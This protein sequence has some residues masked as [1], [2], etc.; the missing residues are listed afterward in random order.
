MG[1]DAKFD[2]WSAGQSYE[3]YMGRWS[4]RIAAEYLK[5]LDLNENAD[6]LE[7]GCGTGALSSQILSDCSPRSLTITDASEDF[8]TH[9]RGVISDPKAKFEVA[10]AQ[11][12]PFETASVDVVTSALVFNF[13]PDK[14]A[15][16]LEMQRVLR[17]GGELTFYVWDYSGGGIGLVDAFWKTAAELDP[18]AA[19]LDEAARF[20]FC[21]PEG[22]KEICASAGIADARVAAIEIQ[23]EFPDFEAFWKPFTMGAGPAPG[24]CGNLSAEDALRLKERLDGKVGTDGPIR[25][26]A[27]AWAVRAAKK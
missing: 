8:L 15:A 25:L 21:T 3:Q 26:P 20:P 9:T 24:Y 23:T 6:W 7:I 13:I 18:K 4:R 1:S 27:R 12:L 22:L 5:W 2:S 19:N 10:D 17:P 16:L 11:A 14:K